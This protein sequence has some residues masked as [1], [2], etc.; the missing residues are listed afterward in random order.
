MAPAPHGAENAGQ[1]WAMRRLL[2]YFCL[3]VLI[4]PAQCAPDMV[5][6]DL[7]V[8][9]PERDNLMRNPGL[10]LASSRS[11]AMFWQVCAE[12]LDPPRRTVR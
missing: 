4:A 1:R 8:N 10:E 7:L 11:K 2:A 12:V 3:V 5:E 9:K 6:N